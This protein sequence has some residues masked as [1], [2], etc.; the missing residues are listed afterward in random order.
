MD[1]TARWLDL[2]KSVDLNM[3]EFATPRNNYADEHAESDLQKGMPSTWFAARASSDTLDHPSTGMP[4][5]GSIF[6]AGVLGVVLYSGALLTRLLYSSGIRRRPTSDQLPYDPDPVLGLRE[7]LRDLRRAD[8]ERDSLR[9][10]AQSPR[11]L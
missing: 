7:L 11:E 10:F 1:F 4:K 2:P 6:L 3:S 5:F 8:Q 9:P